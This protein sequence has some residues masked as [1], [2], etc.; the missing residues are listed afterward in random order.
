M[1]CYIEYSAVKCYKV[2]CSAVL[3]RVQCSGER[4]HSC[5]WLIASVPPPLPNGLQLL[6]MP[7]FKHLPLPSC[8]LIWMLSVFYKRHN[9]NIYLTIKIKLLVTRSHFHLIILYGWVQMTS[10]QLFRWTLHKICSYL[11][12]FYHRD[13][14]I[15]HFP[16]SDPGNNVGVTWIFWFF[17]YNIFNLKSRNGPCKNFNTFTIGL[18]W[19]SIALQTL[20]WFIH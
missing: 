15:W 16:A 1:Q 13:V 19:I 12:I 4:Q 17:K 14:S 11:H 18:V 8:L 3:H 9:K 2:Q 5:L 7:F 6:L 10:I 20:L